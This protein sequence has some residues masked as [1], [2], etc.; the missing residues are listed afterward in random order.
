[1]LAE[2]FPAVAASA[3]SAERNASASGW[4]GK[5][6]ANVAGAVSVRR[7]GEV[8]GDDTEAHL[9]RAGGRLDAG[10][11]AGALSEM[12]GLDKPARAAASSWIAQASERLAVDRDTRNLADRLVR[13]LPP[14]PAAGKAG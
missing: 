10:D 11:L 12:N 6:W 14:K 5:L 7:I 2:Q 8:N 13:N 9:A 1:M 3:L 4:I